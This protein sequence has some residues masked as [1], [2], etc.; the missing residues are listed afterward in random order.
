[1]LT[2]HFRG[3]I[4]LLAVF[5]FA[6]GAARGAKPDEQ[7]QSFMLKAKILTVAE[8]NILYS[9]LLAA[10][11]TNNALPQIKEE[12]LN[13]LMGYKG[14]KVLAAPMIAARVGQEA[15]IRV[16]SQIQ[17]FDPQTNGSFALKTLPEK[18]SPGIRLAATINPTT[19]GNIAVNV[20]L[21]LNTLKERMPIQGVS[22]DV[23]LPLIQKRAIKTKIEFRLDQWVLVGRYLFQDVSSGKQEYLAIFVQVTDDPPTQ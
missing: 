7:P 6:V 5:L 11:F 12:L 13:D 17:Y 15:I 16:Q 23:G 21:Q 3:I 19:A 2:K 8:S 4:S 1:M 22:M 9:T 10:T 18:E 20:D 14:V